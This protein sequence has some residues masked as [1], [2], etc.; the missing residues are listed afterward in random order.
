LRRRRVG[1]PVIAAMRAASGEEGAAGVAND[2]N[3]EP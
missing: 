1:E 2:S 3:S